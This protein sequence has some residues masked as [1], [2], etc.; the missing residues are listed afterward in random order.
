MNANKSKA[1]TDDPLTHELLDVIDTVSEDVIQ[2]P[3]PSRSLS[4]NFPPVRPVLYV[5]LSLQDEGVGDINCA[6]N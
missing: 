4:S 2:P 3:P 6:C 5:H 1:T